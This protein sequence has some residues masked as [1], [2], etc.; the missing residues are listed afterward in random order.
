MARDFDGSG[1]YLTQASEVVN[2]DGPFTVS[3]WAYP[4]GSDLD[5][6]WWQGEDGTF[7][8]G[9]DIAT[10]GDLPSSEVG[11][12]TYVS[13]SESYAATS[14]AFNSSAWNHICGIVTSTTSRRII[15][16]GDWSNSGTST[17]SRNLSTSDTMRVARPGHTSSV[18]FDGRLAQLALWTAALVQWEVEALAD[19]AHPLLIRPASLKEIWMIAGDSPEKGL[20]D[21]GLTL[22]VSGTPDAIADPKGIVF[23]KQF[24][25]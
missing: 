23:P 22:T 16:N 24:A 10:R 1:D 21:S 6:V 17:T 2:E 14:N 11:L 19:G 12:T 18:D 9:H 7:S 4:E 5:V 25:A 13:G 20:L 8:D 15:L 3:I